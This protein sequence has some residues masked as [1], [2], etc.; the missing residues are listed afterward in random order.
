MSSLQTLGIILT[1]VPFFSAPCSCRSILH[2]TEQ[3]SYCQY[4]ALEESKVWTS[5]K[6]C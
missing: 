6:F 1:E 4:I 3:L 5:D 2:I